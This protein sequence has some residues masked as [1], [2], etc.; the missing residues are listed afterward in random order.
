M[1]SAR[2]WPRIRACS[3]SS[4]S[5]SARSGRCRRPTAARRCWCRRRSRCRTRSARRPAGGSTAT[6]WSS[7]S[8]PA[9]RPRCGGCG[10]S[11]SGR[12]WRRAS[13][14]RRWRCA[15][16]R[17]SASASR[18]WPNGSATLLT[19]RRAGRRG[20]DLRARRRRARP[21]LD[22][23]RRRRG[24]TAASQ[25]ALAALG[26]DAYGTD[27]DDLATAALAGS[28]RWAW[29]R[30]RRWEADTDGALLAILAAAPDR[31]GCRAL[32]RRRA[33]P[34][35][36]GDGAARGRGAP[37]L[38][39]AAGRPRAQP[40]P[41]RAERARWPWRVTELRIHGSGPQRLRRAAFAALD[42]VR[43]ISSSGR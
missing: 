12:G 17:P 15:R 41:R 37:G 21:V 34:R 26:D 25:R 23:R 9:C 40:G 10:P 11:R 16:S 2:I 5:A 6:A 7:C 30:S 32:P 1:R 20:R 35:A 31:E 18:R 33:R 8:C 24:S 22:P 28:A 4:R 42:A 14:C 19:D 13:R 39:P 3:P 29:P 36:C 38:A 27:A 43:R